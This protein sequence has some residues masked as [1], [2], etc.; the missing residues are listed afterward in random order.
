MN[1]AEALTLAR[2]AGVR[3]RADGD[4]LLLES[5]APPPPAVLDLLSRHK[6]DIMT[7][8]ALTATRAAGSRIDSATAVSGEP[9]HAG[10]GGRMP[11]EPHWSLD[12]T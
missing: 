4:D 1:A 11:H 3:V 2:A 9:E 10:P 12:C 8:A 7:H 5:S 6:A